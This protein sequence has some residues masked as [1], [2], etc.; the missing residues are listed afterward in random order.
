MTENGLT[1]VF[2]S[3]N[4]FEELTAN[5]LPE[6][7]NISNDD[8][9]V[10]SRSPKKG[11]EPESV[12][13]GEVNGKAHAFVGL[14]RIGGIMVYDITDPAN[15]TYVNYINTRD[16]SEVPDQIGEGVEHLTGDV[17]PEGMYFIS[18]EVSPSKTPILLSAFEVS[19]TVAA[20]SAGEVPT[21]IVN[22]IEDEADEDVK[23]DTENSA[24][25]DTETPETGN[26]TSVV[27]VSAILLIGV[28]CIVFRYLSKKRTNI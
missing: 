1:L 26:T 14:E 4:D 3:G 27:L 13:V 19:G 22:N 28:G 21:K 15:A 2:D 12:V 25:D 16:F 18:A 10:D 11:P 6:Y 24:S 23:D 20:Y 17:A 5:Y 9:E 8:N 7:F